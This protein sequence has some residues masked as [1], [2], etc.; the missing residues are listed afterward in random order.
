MRKI[1][2]ITV[3]LGLL[4]GLNGLTLARPVD[5]V[6]QAKI[7]MEDNPF[8]RE[9]ST[10]FSG[11]DFFTSQA[12]ETVWYGGTV[13]AGGT[14]GPLGAV[15]GKWTWSPAGWGGIPHS[16]LY[17]DG[18]T[19]LDFLSSS[20]VYFRVHDL[21]DTPCFGTK[22][23]AWGTYVAWAGVTTTEGGNLCYAAGAGYGNSFNQ[24]FQNTIAVSGDATTTLQ[25]DYAYDSEVGYDS[26]HVD[27]SV[28]AGATWIPLPVNG[29]LGG[30][31][32]TGS[33][34]ESVNIGPYL[35]GAGNIELR[36]RAESDGGWSDEDGLNATACGE[37]IVDNIVITEAVAG[38]I[39]SCNF[40]AG[41]CGWQWVGAVG[42]GN[43]V[44]LD[45]NPVIDDPCIPTDPLWCQMGDSVVVM[46]D[47]NGP[48]TAPHWTNQENWI[49]SPK[50]PIKGT[51]GDGLPGHMFQFERF[52]NL[53]LY[54]H[55]FLQWFVRYFPY[56]CG[57]GPRWSPWRNNNT[58]YYSATKACIL[59]AFDVSAFMPVCIESAQ[60]AMTTINLCSQDPWKFGCT[61]VNNTT[62]YFDNARFGCTGLATA[63]M[64]SDMEWDKYLDMFPTDGTLSCASTAN[65]GIAN[66]GGQPA[67]MYLGDTLVV[68]GTTCPG[69]TGMEVWLHFRVIPG[70]CTNTAATWFGVYP[71]YVWHT[72]RMDTAQRGAALSTTAWMGAFHEA[73]PNY[74]LASGRWGGEAN[75]ILPDGLFT[76]G[77][78]VDYYVSTNYVGSGVSFELR[79]EEPGFAGLPDD[80]E[81]LPSYMFKT[82]PPTAPCVLYCDHA[83]SRGA[84]RWMEDAL[85]CV[86]TNWDRYD[87]RAPTSGMRD[88]IGRITNMEKGA[89]LVQLQGYKS[90]L[91]DCDNI[92]T[93]G[94]T[95]TDATLFQNFLA[96]ATADAPRFL[97]IQGNEVARYLN[98]E[99]TRKAFMNT[100]M[101]A[102]YVARY[103]YVTGGNT[104]YCVNLTTVAN[105]KIHAGVVGDTIY[106]VR[107]NMCP[108][109][110]NIIGV[111]G[112][113]VTG[114]GE[115]EFNDANPTVHL[116]AVSNEVRDV[117]LNLL[118]RTVLS[119]HGVARVASKNCPGGAYRWAAGDSTGIC[120]TPL[121]GWQ[122]KERDNVRWGGLYG[123]CLAYNTGTPIPGAVNVGTVDELKGAYPNPMNPST[124]ISFAVKSEG[125]VSLRVFDAS[126]RLVKTLV[127]TKLGAG[128][129]TVTWDGSNDRGVKVGSGVFFY[130]IETAGGFKTAKKIVILK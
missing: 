121:K 96:A 111:Q 16:G 130:Q 106:A 63:P 110:F 41:A 84:Q 53:P 32:G 104:A 34:T 31:S 54:D 70:S 105:N 6:N 61:F 43:W 122:R 46:Y 117:G 14:G 112:G 66:G 13:L 92:Y 23:P 86:P 1:L 114:V 12:A 108:N 125:K 22:P 42:P 116:A 78:H 4:V 82:T 48:P 19:S 10:A 33:G 99:A 20:D 51:A 57:F 44:R 124:T 79:N 119:S 129:H 37:F 39:H 83:D 59:G 25:F 80:V 95:T 107:G 120:T 7:A 58:V 113:S 35:A 38:V 97:S 30:Y 127:D 76:P 126:G 55:V 26:C 91:L 115:L 45:Y 101:Q 103:Y 17:L 71:P 24:L 27:I 118:Y 65:I 75:D 36:F 28:D 67:Y 89:T 100:Y 74:G 77:T 102:T 3:A 93:D 62:P 69:F 52:V 85:R 68:D 49:I 128:N 50:I 29:G 21:N 18:W 64:V 40:E 56:D 5:V 11:P 2:F 87:K 109:T 47:P 72:A 8:T 15:G 73:D 9:P 60:I 88:G 90:V 81:V 98:A 94:M 123:Y